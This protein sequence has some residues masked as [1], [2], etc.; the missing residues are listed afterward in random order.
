VCNG[1]QYSACKITIFPLANQR[2]IHIFTKKPHFI[3]PNHKLCA[4]FAYLYDKKLLNTLRFNHLVLKFNHT[5]KY[6][7]YG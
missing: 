5:N 4:T 1:L 6:F 3:I 2:K 7:H